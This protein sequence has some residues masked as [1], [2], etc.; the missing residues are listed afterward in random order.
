MREQAMENKTR[1]STGR[2]ST[3]RM[4]FGTVRQVRLKK[5]PT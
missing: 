4:S 1:G 5:P 3:G 2:M